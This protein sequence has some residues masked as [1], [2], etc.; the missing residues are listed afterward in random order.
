MTDHCLAN[1]DCRLGSFSTMEEAMSLVLWRAAD[2]GVNGVSDAVYKSKLPSAK[3]TTRLGTSDKLQW[4]AENGLLPLQPHQACYGR[5]LIHPAAIPNTSSTNQAY[6]S[7]FVKVRRMHEG[8]NPKTGETT[9]SLRS[10]VEEVPGNLLRLAAQRSL[11]PVDDVE[12]AEPAEGR[13]DASD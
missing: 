13:P 5:T 2:C 8:F 1:F 9:Q 4:L 10:T 11:F 6:G 7:Y 3:S 12:V